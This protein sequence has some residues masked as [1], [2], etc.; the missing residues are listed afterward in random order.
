MSI[1][2][3][4]AIRL[5]QRLADYHTELAR[6]AVLDVVHEH[7]EHLAELLANEVQRIPERTAA[8]ERMR[9]RHREQE[10]HDDGG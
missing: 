6:T 3:E 5:H 10:E 1:P 4:E 8:V 9:A 2:D 7:H